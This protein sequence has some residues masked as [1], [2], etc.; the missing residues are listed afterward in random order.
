MRSPS[1]MEKRRRRLN[2]IASLSTSRRTKGLRKPCLAGQVEASERLTPRGFKAQPA[3]E[4]TEGLF[5]N[6]SRAPPLTGGQWRFSQDATLPQVSESRC[7]W[8]VDRYRRILQREIAGFG[9]T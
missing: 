7:Q 8:R 6:Q 5:G 4:R 1:E 9:G 3:T 2:V